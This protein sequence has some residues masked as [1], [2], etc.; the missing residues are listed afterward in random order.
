MMSVKDILN[1]PHVKDIYYLLHTIDKLFVIMGEIRDQTPSDCCPY[2][3]RDFHIDS[4]PLAKAQAAY[5][6]Y[7]RFMNKQP[8]IKIGIASIVTNLPLSQ[9]YLD[10][11]LKDGE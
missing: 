4:C 6:E 11:L 7:R 10:D 2:C 9:E 1:M 5:D 3:D 8:F